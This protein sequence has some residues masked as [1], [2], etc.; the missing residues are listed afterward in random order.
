MRIVDVDGWVVPDVVGS[1]V[2]LVGFD[3]GPM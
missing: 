1:F 2:G 3:A